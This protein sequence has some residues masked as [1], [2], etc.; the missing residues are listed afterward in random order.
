VP[1]TMSRPRL[2]VMRSREEE[3]RDPMFWWVELGVIVAS[4]VAPTSLVETFEHSAVYTY[5]PDANTGSSLRPVFEEVFEGDSQGVRVRR[6]YHKIADSSYTGWALTNAS[7]VVYNGPELIASLELALTKDLVFG[8]KLVRGP[9]GCGKTYMICQVVGPT[10]VVFAPVKKVMASTRVRV[11]EKSQQ[12]AA[13]AAD[14]CKTLDSYLVNYTINK[15]VRDLSADR[16]LADEAFMAHSGRWWAAAALLGV[17]HVWFY[18]DPN[19]IPPVVRAGAPQSFL[20]VDKCDEVNEV[21]LNWRNPA[22]AIAAWGSVFNWKV[23]AKSDVVGSLVHVPS[24]SS[25]PVWPGQVVLGFYQADKKDLHK[26]YASTVPKPRIATVHE[27]QGEDLQSVKLHRF[28]LRRRTDGMALFDREPYVLVAM[29]RHKENFAY[30]S[31]LLGDL[32][33]QWVK[34][35]RDPRRVQAASQVQSQGCSKEFI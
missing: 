5:Q 7:S 28:D 25:L 16:L 3:Y 8:T 24:A 27:V 22:S 4:A 34:R 21:W 23:R 30:I 14:R 18:G 2:D 12:L 31:P 35:G 6:V 13:T 29:S 33:E 1:T 19:Q 20:K 10:D 11:A 17:K 15:R 26:L 32:V 9:P